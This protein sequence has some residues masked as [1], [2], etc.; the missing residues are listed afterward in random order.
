MK[1]LI[2]TRI[3]RKCELCQIEDEVVV[4]VGV[5]VVEGEEEKEVV[6]VAGG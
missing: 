3:K 2:S 5:K 4:G 1:H 6:V